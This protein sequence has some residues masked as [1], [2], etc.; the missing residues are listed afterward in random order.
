[1]KKS[2][3]EILGVTRE[4]LTEESLR[5]A[6]R[7]KAQMYHPDR[8]GGDAELFVELQRAYDTLRDADARAHY[9]ATGE[10]RPIFCVD[11]EAEQLIA[12]AFAQW[13]AFWMT[14]QRAVPD[15]PIRFI[16]KELAGYSAKLAAEQKKQEAAEK[17]LSALRPRITREGGEVDVISGHLE[18]VARQV[19][20]QKNLTEKNMKVSALAI[21]LL[22]SYRY[23][24]EEGLQTSATS[25]AFFIGSF[26]TSTNA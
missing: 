23:T 19:R 12:Q 3:Y 15:D 16:Q 14:D 9:D 11:R 6:Y 26:Y 1:M 17:K 21:Q 20:Q 22:P 13:L 2:Y 8:E 5:A 25:G 10:D 18:A 4:G 24:P 7:T